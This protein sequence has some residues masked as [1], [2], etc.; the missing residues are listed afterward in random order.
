ML[1]VSLFSLSALNHSCDPD[2]F[3]LFD[4]PKALIRPLKS[5]LDGRPFDQ[6][7]VAPVHSRRIVRF[8]ITI[9]YCDLLSTTKERQLKLQ[10][11]YYFLCNCSICGNKRRVC[12][13]FLSFV[14][15][16][17]HFGR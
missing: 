1:T 2:A 17:T 14:V 4:G 7:S 11:Q 5:G 3:I 13:L 9:S 16:L 15:N 12:F 8:Q 10:Q 6:V